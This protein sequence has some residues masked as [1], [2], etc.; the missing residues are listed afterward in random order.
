MA[1][2]ELGNVKEKGN[3]AFDYAK[4]KAPEV[5]DKAKEKG[6]DAWDKAKTK[7]EERK[8]Q[9]GSDLFEDIDLKDE[10]ISSLLN[11]EDK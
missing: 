11:E 8:Q 2:K 4:E 10:D 5:W 3:V 6:I 1:K 9:G 7:L